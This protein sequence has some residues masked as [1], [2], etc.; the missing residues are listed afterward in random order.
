VRTFSRT[1]SVAI[2]VFA[3]CVVAATVLGIL[4]VGLEAVAALLGA[5]SAP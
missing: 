5:L 3:W 2:H 4:F 1:A